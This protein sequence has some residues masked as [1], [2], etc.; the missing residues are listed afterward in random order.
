MSTPALVQTRGAWRRLKLKVDGRSEGTQARDPRLGGYSRGSSLE[1]RDFFYQR[2]R[3][4]IERVRSATQSP[5]ESTVVAIQS[6]ARAAG[7]PTIA[8]HSR[9]RE[10]LI[11]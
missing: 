6:L 7:M 11:A 3:F 4:T 1:P 5:I 2:T 8:T 10:T 9:H